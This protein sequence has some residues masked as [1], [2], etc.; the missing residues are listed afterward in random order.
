MSG[1]L[2]LGKEGQVGWELQK[3]LGAFG[4]VVA[5]SHH[6]LDLKD[7]DQLR[8]AVQQL[9]PDIIINAA[10]Y[11]NVDKAE[12]ERD[13]AEAVNAR[14]PKILAEEAARLKCLLI[15]LSTDYVFDGQH[16]GAYTEDDAPNPI[17]YYGQTKLA[18]EKAVQAVD[19]AFWIF[20]T[21]WVY[22]RRRTSFLTHVL[23]W[24]RSQATVRVVDDQYGSPTWCRSL[25]EG[26]AAAAGLAASHDH[27]WAS[28]RS[29]V[30]HVAC[31]GS[32]S[33]LEMAQRILALDPSADQQIATRLIAAKS[34]EFPSPAARPRNSALDCRKFERTFSVQLPDWEAALADAMGD[35]VPDP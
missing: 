12:T 5:T 33:R 13:L 23:E 4:E 7:E 18:G 10:A 11:T 22:S 2:L 29:G 25:A 30:Y 9:E 16:S 24:S 6:E 35:L 1:I 19:G 28:A 31:S 26:I 21:S 20:R 3:G 17:S 32:A 14:A 34:D 15:H 8:S 27:T